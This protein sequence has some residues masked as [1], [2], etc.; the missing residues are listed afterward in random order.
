MSMRYHNTLRLLSQD[1][2]KRK[3]GF[4]LFFILIGFILGASSVLAFYRLPPSWFRNVIEIQSEEPR[5]MIEYALPNTSKP[6][7]LPGIPTA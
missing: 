1:M 6:K 2:A 7:R 5:D 3:I 4:S